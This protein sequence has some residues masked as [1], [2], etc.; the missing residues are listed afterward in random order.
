MSGA[1]LQLAVL[2]ESVANDIMQRTERFPK[3]LR[4][5]LASRI[6]NLAIDVLEGITVARYSRDRAREAALARLDLQMTRLRVLLRL[7]HTRNCLDERA[8]LYVNGRVDEAGRMLGG[9]RNTATKAAS[10]EIE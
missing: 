2:W 4:Y 1:Q 6:D 10:P 5:S 3:S 9:W 7:A 8:W